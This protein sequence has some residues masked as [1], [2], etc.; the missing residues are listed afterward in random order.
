[1]RKLG[2]I[3]AFICFAL[4]ILS[5]VWALKGEYSHATWDLLLAYVIDRWGEV[6]KGE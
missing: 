5:V 1:L 6:E 2:I 3:G 4:A